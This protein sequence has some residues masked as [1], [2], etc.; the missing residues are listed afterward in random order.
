MKRFLSLILSIALLLSLMPTGLFS[1]TA[2]AASYLDTSNFWKDDIYYMCKWYD[3]SDIGWGTVGNVYIKSCKESKSG[4]LTIGYTT[5]LGSRTLFEGILSG[6]FNNCDNLTSVT[7]PDSIEV[8][9]NAFSDCDSLTIYCEDSTKPSN[10]SSN[11]NSSNS[12]VV[13]D[14]YNNDVAT[15]GYIFLTQKLKCELKFSWFQSPRSFSFIK[16]WWIFSSLE[17]FQEGSIHIHGPPRCH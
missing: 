1:I 5:D 9:S 15:D 7:I 13:W 14:C 16:G 2:N 10:W 11:W 4:D 3:Y 17:K 6:A 12:P 8:G